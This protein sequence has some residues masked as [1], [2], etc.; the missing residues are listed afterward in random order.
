MKC[1]GI[2]S[3][4]LAFWLSELYNMT[5]RETLFPELAASGSTIEQ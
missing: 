3:T 1:T 5:K 4:G 2:T